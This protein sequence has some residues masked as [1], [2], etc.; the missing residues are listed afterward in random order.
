[1]SELM[2]L[3]SDYQVLVG[4][5]HPYRAGGHIPG[6]AAGEYPAAGLFD[7]NGKDVALDPGANR[8]H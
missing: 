7:M 6:A 1:M 4:G 2:E 8:R 3:F 5:A